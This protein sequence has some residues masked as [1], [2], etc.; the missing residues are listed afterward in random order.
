MRVDDRCQQQAMRRSSPSLALAALLLATG[1]AERN[2]VEHPVTTPPPS[3]TS[4]IASVPVT[5]T[6]GVPPTPAASEP[7]VVPAADWA[8]VAPSDAGLDADALA[9]I[10]ETA[11]AGESDC[12]VVV[13][14]GRLV[15]DWQ[16]G[17]TTTDAAE[18]V[19]SATKS[20]TS[21]LVGIAQADGKLSID[22]PASTWITEWKGTPSEAITV[23][24]LLSNDSGRQ[25][26]TAI[27]Y[28][29]L[30]KAQDRTAFAVALGQDAQPG[31]VWAYNNSAI[32]TLEE[33]LA[34]ATGIDVAAYA[35]TELF[36]PLGMAHT[37]M[38][39]DG[40]GNPQVFQ[41]VRS[42]CQDMA[43]FGL[44][45]LN[46]GRWGDRQI[47]P[48]DWVAASTGRSS[49]E[50]NQAYG[51]LWW[52]NRPGTIVSPLVATGVGQPPAATGQIAPGAPEDMFWAIG[53]GNQIVQVDPGSRTVVV[54]LGPG[55]R[56]SPPTFG[57]ADASRIVT[58]AVVR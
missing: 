23:R 34:Q 5:S 24:D 15:G 37:A 14:D 46:Q 32:Q 31:Q 6:S 45:M 21:V 27:D 52:L 17:S 38:T 8:N 30:I 36:G 19:F 18:N 20:I 35:Q 47:V 33:V 13:R 22:Q 7:A 54:R 49:T 41:G 9:A 57:P 28:V 58:E 43:R 2:T 26:S 51:Y 39:R 11:R 25:W 48:E 56:P 29:Q 16:F 44:L 12:L 1:C 40:A 10:A 53:L 4:T 3:S 55:Q 42:T 50:L